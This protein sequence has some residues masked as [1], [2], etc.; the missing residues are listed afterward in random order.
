M[1]EFCSIIY[2]TAIRLYYGLFPT[3]KYCSSCC[4]PLNVE[5]IKV[6]NFHLATLIESIAMVTVMNNIQKL[7]FFLFGNKYDFITLTSL[8]KDFMI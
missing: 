4:K 1:Y 5:A 7:F 2:Y 8:I 3:S 6:P